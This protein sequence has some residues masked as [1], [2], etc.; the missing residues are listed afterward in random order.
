MLRRG[1]RLADLQRLCRG[2]NK[3]DAVKREVLEGVLRRQQMADVRRIEA[4]T[5]DGE[6]HV[7]SPDDAGRGSATAGA[8]G[9][10]TSLHTRATSTS[11]G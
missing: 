8:S 10:F 9:V 5:K 2:G 11:P 3:N 4:A 1:D 7:Q 6:T